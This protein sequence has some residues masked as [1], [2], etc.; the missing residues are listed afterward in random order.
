VHSETVVLE[1]FNDP[2]LNSDI[3]RAISVLSG[4]ASQIKN[5]ANVVRFAIAIRKANRAFRDL[6]AAV[7]PAMEGKASSKRKGVDVPP[8]RVE[9]ILE[10]L[11][12]LSRVV[13]Y[14]HMYSRRAGLTNNSL[15]SLPVA[16]LQKHSEDLQSLV[17]WLHLVSQREAV[18]S[19]FDRGKSEIAS[20]Q[21]FSLEQEF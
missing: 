17:D 18:A 7:Y 5:K 21:L 14:V 6:F 9:E 2:K 13:E 19:I 1:S 11:L 10:N 20:G 12:Y 4:L 15:T 16:E 3:F 8:K